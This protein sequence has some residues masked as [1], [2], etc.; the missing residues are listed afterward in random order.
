MVSLGLVFQ[1]LSLCSLRRGTLGM[2]EWLYTHC[3][4]AASIPEG[5]T[6]T[7]LHFLSFGC[8]T[9]ISKLIFSQSLGN[10]QCVSI[11]LQL[12]QITSFL[13]LV[14]S[15]CCVLFLE[16]SDS[17]L[18]HFSLHL[19]TYDIQGNLQ[20]DS[21]VTVSVIFENKST[22]FLKSM[23]LNVLDSLNTKML[24]PEGSS[25]HDGIPVPFQLPP[26]MHSSAQGSWLA[27]HCPPVARAAWT[28]CCFPGKHLCLDV[29]RLSH[30]SL[31]RINLLPVWL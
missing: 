26:G 11:I 19:Q 12:Y 10:H 6:I 29:A 30:S 15:P 16:V 8:P 23:E 28:S 18:W 17:F 5:R 9:L 13:N 20:N 24:R 21:Q 7:K 1:M 3:W 22:S 27:L 31:E 14:L 2:V 4:R 25:V